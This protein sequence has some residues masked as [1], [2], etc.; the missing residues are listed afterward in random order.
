[1]RSKVYTGSKKK[2][3]SLKSAKK[4]QKNGIVIVATVIN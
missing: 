3:I 2:K 4:W 1:M